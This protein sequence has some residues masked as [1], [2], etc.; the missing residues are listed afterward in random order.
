M[1]QIVDM[2]HA[3]LEA[4]TASMWRAL[5]D[6][7]R[8]QILD[9]LS[10]GPRITGD[11]ASHFPI[12]RIAVMRHLEVLAEADLI[13]SRKR[14]R[15]R[16][17]FF[18]AVPFQR[19]HQRWADPIASEFASGL[20]R[21]QEQVE[22]EH[23]QMDLGP[24][25]VDIALDVRIAG[26]PHAVFRALTQDV[27]GWWGYPA[28]DARAT[29]LS[30]EPGL[31]G[32]FV[33]HWD[34]G[35]QLLASVTAWAPDRHLRLTGSFHF[36]L[37]LCEA[38]FDLEEVSEGTLLRFSFRAFGAIEPETVEVMKSGWRGLIADRLK[39]LVET[40]VRTGIDAGDSNMRAIGDRPPRPQSTRS[41]KQ[42]RS[43]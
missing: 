34:Q 38:I 28:L 3:E 7:T 6:P 5:A 17:H 15:E 35:G 14:G 12:S 2:R 24:P 42:R 19:L 40:G 16:W 21:L 29:G 13:T 43:T 26:S 1:A 18:N 31:A 33:E 20:L 9:L 10:V 32:G 27:G 37:A 4:E 41:Q 30:L 25:A 11:I 23:G 36:G 39:M 22:V 8:R